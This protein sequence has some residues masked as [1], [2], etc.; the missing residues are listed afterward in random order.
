MDGPKIIAGAI[1]G[2]VLAVLGLVLFLPDQPP[3]DGAT[4][5]SGVDSP[6]PTTR[7]TVP[8]ITAG[9]VQFESTVL[10]PVEVVADDGVVVLEFDFATIAPSEGTSEPLSDGPV[11]D[12][13]PERWALSTVSG[14]GTIET[15][16]P[17]AS[18]VRFNVRAGLLTEHIASVRLIG[19][20]VAVPNH[21]RIA[22]D[23]V[24][25]ASGTFAGGTEVTVAIILEQSNPTIVQLDVDQVR[26][27]WNR[28]DFGRHLGRILWS[29]SGS[30]NPT[31]ISA[32]KIQMI[33]QQGQTVGG[34]LSMP[35]PRDPT[36]SAGLVDLFWDRGFNAHPDA[37]QPR[38]HH[39]RG[40]TG[41]L[42]AGGCRLRRGHRSL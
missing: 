35:S 18:S 12:A 31:G 7:T 6:D 10:I 34:Y 36:R 22:L 24:A 32:F 25:G 40:A 37:R 42:P 41:L 17:G 8:W 30:G 14:G 21:E 19:W 2:F 33:D 39:G 11:I 29:L 16:D 3:A 38:A 1:A 4:A 13:L 5:D 20:R 15:T 9:E 26:D 28:I 27:R 23:V